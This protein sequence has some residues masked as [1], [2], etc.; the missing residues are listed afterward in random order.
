MQHWKKVMGPRFAHRCAPERIIDGKRLIVFVGNAVLKQEM[1]F[2][3]RRMLNTIKSLPGCEGINEL[4]FK[5][6]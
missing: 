3:K 5:H 1:E 4:I 2:E 6:S